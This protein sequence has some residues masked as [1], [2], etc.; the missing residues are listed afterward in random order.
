MNSCNQ[1]ITKGDKPMQAIKAAPDFTLLDQDRNPHKLSDYS[2]DYVL[3]YFYPKDD[4]PGCTKEA[5]MIRD[6]YAEFEEKKIKVFGISADSPE[7]HKKFIE[8][9][10]LP[11]TLLSDENKAVAKL[12]E[13]D[14]LFLKRISYL[15]GPGSQII[16]FYPNVDPANHATEILAD[17]DQ[18]ISK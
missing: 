8:K 14:G 11:F 16:K 13:A 12:Y 1:E 2:S 7:S 17:I 9:Y 3:I 10:H 4:T 5:C 18:A 6:N 15:I